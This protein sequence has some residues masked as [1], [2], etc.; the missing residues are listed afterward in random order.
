MRKWSILAA[1]TLVLGGCTPTDDAAPQ[2]QG[3]TLEL[4]G[5]EDWPKAKAGIPLD[6]VPAAPDGFTDK[7]VDRLAED[8]AE[9]G[10]KTALHPDIYTSDSPLEITTEHMSAYTRTELF[11]IAEGTTTPR[12]QGGVRLADGVELASEPRLVSVWRTGTREDDRGVEFLT[13]ELQTR[14]V[15]PV[16]D[17]DG[18]DRLIGFERY[19]YLS[20][21]DPLDS[22]AEFGAALSWVVFGAER[23]PLVDDDWIVPDADFNR[24]AGDFEVFGN[25]IKANE[26]VDR[27]LDDDDNVDEGIQEQCEGD[28]V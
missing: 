26:F 6:D 3:V 23:C 24:V 17:S 4:V 15:Y 5:G 10:E 1:A 9:W 11:E 21:Y 22:G 2:E 20:S 13:V 12:V 16:K 28:L 25:L 7:Q 19:H 18:V 8:L 14:A 27:D